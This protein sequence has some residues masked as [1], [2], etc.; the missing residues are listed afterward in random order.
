MKDP[1]ITDISQNI[2]YLS[3]TNTNIDINII[4]D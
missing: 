1:K 2:W 4:I 3:Y